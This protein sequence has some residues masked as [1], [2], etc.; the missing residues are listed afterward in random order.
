MISNTDYFGGVPPADGTL[1]LNAGILLPR[2]NQLLR[3][4]ETAYP[5]NGI[6]VSSGYRSPQRN[7]QIPGAAPNSLHMRALAVDIYDGPGRPLAMWLLANTAELQ[8][9][10]LYCE[11]FRATPTWCHIQCRRPNSGRLFFIPNMDWA[12]KLGS[13]PLTAE[14]VLKWSQQ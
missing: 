3:A 2:V 14:T 10:D 9:L 13:E 12:K 11:D 1:K 4:Y 7:A 5:G 6:K 8:A